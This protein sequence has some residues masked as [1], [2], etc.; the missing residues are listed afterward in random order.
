MS[1]SKQLRESEELEEPAPIAVKSSDQRQGAAPLPPPVVAQDTKN[2]PDKSVDDQVAA[3][4]KVA[5]DTETPPTK[6]AVAAQ[7]ANDAAIATALSVEPTMLSTEIVYVIPAKD[8]SLTG[9]VIEVSSG[10]QEKTWTSIGSLKGETVP[11]DYGSCLF[12]KGTCNVEAGS[13]TLVRVK[14]NKNTFGGK[15]KNF[16]GMKDDDEPKTRSVYSIGG[17]NFFISHHL[18]DSSDYL[19]RDAVT[20]V[21]RKIAERRLDPMDE[22]SHLQAMLAAWPKQFWKENCAQMFHAKPIMISISGNVIVTP[23]ELCSAAV[24]YSALKD[25][26]P[27]YWLKFASTGKEIGNFPKDTTH[28]TTL[29]MTADPIVK[30][31]V[32]NFIFMA[33][34]E[35]CRDFRKHCIPWIAFIVQSLPHS[36]P[37]RKK[38]VDILSIDSATQKALCDKFGQAW[39]SAGDL[40]TVFSNCR[41]IEDLLQRLSSMLTSGKELTSEER[42]VFT[43]AAFDLL[44]KQELRLSSHRDVVTSTQDLIEAVSKERQCE[45]L[46]LVIRKLSESLYN[47]YLATLAPSELLRLAAETCKRAVALRVSTVPTGTKE[48]EPETQFCRSVVKRVKDKLCVVDPQSIQD[49]RIVARDL[50]ETLSSET[51][52]KLF[53]NGLSDMLVPCDLLARAA[54]FST[55]ASNWPTW[56]R[57]SERTSILTI[58]ERATD[59]AQIY[60][61]VKKFAA[62]VTAEAAEHY[63]DE[64]KIYTPILQRSLHKVLLHIRDLPYDQQLVGILENTLK[65]DSASGRD[66]S[67]GLAQLT[68]HETSRSF[69]RS[70]LDDQSNHPS[71]AFP[72]FTEAVRWCSLIK[73]AANQIQEAVSSKNCNVRFIDECDKRRKELAECEASLQ[74][75]RFAFIKLSTLSE[76]QQFVERIRGAWS[77]AIEALQSF[78]TTT[79]KLIDDSVQEAIRNLQEKQG[80]LATMPLS[81]WTYPEELD[82]IPQDVKNS[83]DF[84]KQ[85]EVSSELARLANREVLGEYETALEQNNTVKPSMSFAETIQ[86]WAE[87]LE[88]TKSRWAKFLED[89]DSIPF[90]EFQRRFSR[91]FEFIELRLKSAGV[92]QTGGIDQVRSRHRVIEG[93]AQLRAELNKAIREELSVAKKRLP[94]P[95]LQNLRCLQNMDETSA[96]IENALIA[97]RD[98]VPMRAVVASCNKL[99]VNLAATSP[100]QEFVALLDSSTT[101]ASALATAHHKITSQRHHPLQLPKNFF[102]GLLEAINDDTLITLFKNHPSLHSLSQLILDRTNGAEARELEALNA[103]EAIHRAFSS[104]EGVQNDFLQFSRNRLVNSVAFFKYMEEVSWCSDVLASNAATLPRVLEIMSDEV[105]QDNAVSTAIELMA[106]TTV[107]VITIGG[108]HVD[109]QQQQQQLHRGDGSNI[110]RLTATTEKRDK[111]FTH[112]DLEDVCFQ[113]TLAGANA[114]QS[115]ADVLANYVYRYQMI[116]S[117]LLLCSELSSA[118]HPRFQL[119]TLRIEMGRTTDDIEQE[120]CSELKSELDRW[121]EFKLRAE[122]KHPLLSFLHAHELVSCLSAVDSTKTS[123]D[124]VRLASTLRHAMLPLTPI[125]DILDAVDEVEETHE[126]NENASIGDELVFIH[127]VMHRSIRTSTQ[128]APVISQEHA[129]AHNIAQENFNR[130]LRTHGLRDALLDNPES[131]IVIIQLPAADAV[132]CSAVSIAIYSALSERLPL[133]FEMLFCD[134]DTTHAAAFVRRWGVDYSDMIDTRLLFCVTGVQRLKSRHQAELLDSILLQKSRGRTQNTEEQPKHATSKLFLVIADQGRDSLISTQLRN[135]SVIPVSSELVQSATAVCKAI[136]E[137][138]PIVIAQSTSPSSGKTQTAMQLAFKSKKRF[139]SAIVDGSVSCFVDHVA[140]VTQGRVTAEEP[141]ILHLSVS[142]V[143]HGHRMNDQILEYAVLGRIVDHKVCKT[144]LRAPQDRIIVEIPSQGNL[145]KTFRSE[146]PAL[147]WFAP[148]AVKKRIRLSLVQLAA[149]L[150]PQCT[151]HNVISND[152]VNQS[153]QKA[154][155]V[156]SAFEHAAA[157]REQRLPHFETLETQFNSIDTRKA[158]TALI[159]RFC[160]N[161][162]H[163]NFGAVVRFT[164]FLIPMLTG[165]HEFPPYQMAS[166]ELELEDRR[167]GGT[168]PQHRLHNFRALAFF[169]VKFSLESGEELAATSVPAADNESTDESTRLEKLTISFDNLRRPFVLFTEGTYEFITTDHDD[170]LIASVFNERWNNQQRLAQQRAIDFDK[171]FDAMA[172]DLENQKTLTVKQALQ[173]LL[174]GS[175]VPRLNEFRRILPALGLQSNFGILLIGAL[176]LVKSKKL[177][178]QSRFCDAVKTHASLADGSSELARV[179]DEWK[180]ESAS[181]TVKLGKFC[182]CAEKWLQSLTASPK[183][184]TAPFVLTPDSFARLLA[185]KTRLLCGIPVVFQGE[186]G[187]GKTHLLGHL[188]RV[189][190]TIFEIIN[191]H[192]GVR[193]AT[194]LDCIHKVED[195][196]RAKPKKDQIAIV[197]LDEV[198]SMNDVWVAKSLVC[199][200]LLLGQTV[201]PQIHFVC[202]MNPWRLQESQ[203]TPGLDLIAGKSASDSK[204]TAAKE[205]HLV[206]DVNRSPESFMSV[207]W[208]FGLAHNSFHFP[209]DVQTHLWADRADVPSNLARVTDEHIFAE[210]CFSWHLEK[211]TGRPTFD[212]CWDQL[213]SVGDNEGNRHFKHL[214]SLVVVL[215]DTA[216]DKL[217]AIGGVCS[218]SLRDIHRTMALFPLELVLLHYA[219][220]WNLAQ[221]IAGRPGSTKSASLDALVVSSDR[222]CTDSRCRFFRF[223]K[224]IKKFVVQCT[225]ETTAQAILRVAKSAALHQRIRDTIEPVQCILVLEEVGIAVGSK[226][227]PLMVLHSLI[228]RGVEM[229]DGTL[230]RIP[231]IGISNYSLDAAKMNRMRITFRGNPKLDDLVKTA[232]TLMRQQARRRQGG[233]ISTATVTSYSSNT[234][235]NDEWV[236]DYCATFRNLILTDSANPSIKWYYGMRD[237]YS[238]VAM[239]KRHSD[240]CLGDEA[241]EHTADIKKRTFLSHLSWWA[242]QINFG[243][244][245]NNTLGKEVIETL[246]QA[247]CP[248]ADAPSIAAWSLDEEQDILHAD[249]EH[250]GS[251]S[252]LRRAVIFC[253]MCARLHWYNS[254]VHNKDEDSQKPLDSR[255]MLSSLTKSGQPCPTNIHQQATMNSTLAY[256]LHRTAPEV[257]RLYRVRNV[258]MFSRGNAGMEL[259]FRLGFVRKEDAEV[260][261]PRDPSHVTPQQIM[262]DLSRVRRCL[263]TNRTL[264]LVR[265]AHLYEAMFD[266]LNQHFAIEVRG[267]E[268]CFYSTLTV[269]GFTSTIRVSPDHRIILVEDEM[270]IHKLTSPFLN[271]CVKVHLDFES[272][273]T[274]P[275]RRLFERAK[276]EIEDLGHNVA[277]ILIPGFTDET[278]ASHILNIDVSPHDSDIRIRNFTADIIDWLYNLTSPRRLLQAQLGLM[279]NVPAEK[280]AGWSCNPIGATLD[281][282]LRSNSNTIRRHLLVFTEQRE[283]SSDLLITAAGRIF[284]PASCLP[285]RTVAVNFLA[286]DALDPLISGT[287]SSTPTFG[288]FVVDLSSV[289]GETG[290][291]KLDSLLHRVAARCPANRHIVVVAVLSSTAKPLAAPR[292]PSD[293]EATTEAAIVHSFGSLNWRLTDRVDWTMIFMDEV[294]PPADPLID[295]KLFLAEEGATLE[296]HLGQL[297]VALLQAYAAVGSSRSR[298]VAQFLSSGED[299]KTL[300]IAVKTL[301]HPS[302]PAFGYLSKIFVDGMMQ[303]PELSSAESWKALALTTIT[304]S[305]SVRDHLTTFLINVA[306]RAAQLVIPVIMEEDSHRHAIGR[307]VVDVKRNA[308]AAAPDASFCVDHESMETLDALFLELLHSSLVPGVDYALCIQQH[309]DVTFTPSTKMQLGRCRFPFSHRIEVLMN[310]VDG[311]PD[312]QREVYEELFL[313]HNVTT[314]T[315]ELVRFYASDVV[316]RRTK[317][318][319]IP[320]LDCISSLLLLSIPPNSRLTIVDVHAFVHDHSGWLDD[321]YELLR[322]IPSFK[323]ANGVQSQLRDLAHGH[324]NREEDRQPLE[325]VQAQED[326][327]RLVVDTCVAGSTNGFLSLSKVRALKGILPFAQGHWELTLHQGMST[328]PTSQPI[329]EAI[330]QGILRCGD[331]E[332]LIMFMIEHY[333]PAL[334]E[335]APS[336]LSCVIPED[337]G[338]IQLRMLLI[339]EA[340]RCPSPGIPNAMW[341][342][343]LRCILRKWRDTDGHPL[344]DFIGPLL[345]ED[346]HNNPKDERARIVSR[347]AFDIW[348]NDHYQQLQDKIAAAVVNQSSRGIKETDDSLLTFLRVCRSGVDTAIGLAV[349]HH[350]VS[351]GNANPNSTTTTASTPEALRQ[352]RRVESAQRYLTAAFK[353]NAVDEHRR[354]QLG[355]FIAR[356]LYFEVLDLPRFRD[357]LQSDSRK[358]AKVLPTE[359]HDLDFLVTLKATPPPLSVLDLFFSYAP[360]RLNIEKKLPITDGTP[361]VSVAAAL[362]SLALSLPELPNFDTTRFSNSQRGLLTKLPALLKTAGVNPPTSDALLFVA[363]SMETHPFI[364]NALRPG[365]IIQPVLTRGKAPT[366]KRELVSYHASKALDAIVA[367]LQALINEEQNPPNTAAVKDSVRHIQEQILVIR[368][369]RCREP[370]GGFDGCFSVT[371]KCGQCFCGWCF[372]MFGDAHEHLR[373]CPMNPTGGTHGTV[374]QWETSNNQRRVFGIRKYLN[375]V[376]PQLCSAVIGVL[377]PDLKDLHVDIGAIGIEPVTPPK[378]HIVAHDAVNHLVVSTAVSL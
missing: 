175:D 162:L 51:L 292:H 134:E 305:D 166:H 146:A 126:R 7:V 296:D 61:K 88:K 320:E 184:K 321:S 128:H 63:G 269:D 265:A 152:N 242:L 4:P 1:K 337:D 110:V 360:T 333:S 319:A 157:G 12:V 193:E 332:T 354:E 196:L 330:V 197:V 84:W 3:P 253:D 377:L 133:P 16:A 30:H 314:P 201:M 96:Q 19:N 137:S 293:D 43:R 248:Q 301:I 378:T 153:L 112:T 326:L 173:A 10:K 47:G 327:F 169:L 368:C 274:A 120:I 40:R 238:F 69:F 218:V 117:A 190:G 310:I 129:G 20:N 139:A 311:E 14:A 178:P 229:D 230:I 100:E 336:L 206:Y 235:N 213:R 147:E 64:S 276:K 220:C 324:H 127:Q 245:P 28:V 194:I 302:T 328:L 79:V 140:T 215:V 357:I 343:S 171:D 277:R 275:Q 249:P 340:V 342:A 278:L 104:T 181:P 309:S 82:K 281:D 148:L 85:V 161:K 261:D 38:I 362:F 255:F 217:R 68:R 105:D 365:A 263:R 71:W 288:V 294:V 258:L 372:G 239:M 313:T 297:K 209:Q 256:A 323:L 115:K 191:I 101:S 262:A 273:L 9:I 199:D 358:V 92:A 176:E 322:G 367:C 91:F 167:D 329:P 149:P 13:K 49:L 341:A 86:L 66:A 353:S 5:R 29:L 334:N 208:D 315:L 23:E 89:L 35:V 123:V 224:P 234:Q 298:S 370:F 241:G 15:V 284:E 350:L 72:E 80:R 39:M 109:Q 135:T 374:Q 143:A 359:F 67:R 254:R 122:T 306:Q 177:D 174:H 106:P 369:P 223:W 93:N 300:E 304:T 33:V 6:S 62:T 158:A 36:D 347:C 317:I 192:R 219:S 285:P 237:F 107:F 295:P 244:H 207:V 355:E 95:L 257:V 312:V 286:D 280:V 78:S 55:N 356:A 227:N 94:G 376:N 44:R 99:K 203:I 338:S 165:I 339:E 121:K 138:L 130:L 163:V 268:I 59:F 289:N 83:I 348:Q 46:E 371:C 142:H 361:N 37:R 259:L 189:S 170:K 34:G 363:A 90:V 11:C 291:G 22:H 179:S 366:A 118:G 102:P 221:I 266:V 168:M 351:S 124:R 243:G 228:D 2:P 364:T 318:T 21:L 185:V 204:E 308:P 240:Y 131:D 136:C 226:H 267:E 27:D 271:R 200:R 154:L 247:I 287:S 352:K 180:D 156:L 303:Q 155:R 236:D 202:I 73:D 77:N 182:V 260:I 246:H 212:S 54:V 116:K 251:M 141:I 232:K 299:V 41:T 164:Q 57:N 45:L 183:S 24:R 75:E 349:V 345:L 264:I 8:Q 70:I 186:T 65:S 31:A 145:H 74:S 60:A 17:V 198:N 290:S 211:M 48:S 160:P 108:N 56:L 344:S 81:M 225:R 316:R 279:H 172:R 205:L 188:S 132:L 113:L 283:I 114:D 307:N 216:Q 272:A 50:F 97:V 52:C 18:G 25:V 53:D 210:S 214:R 282:V 119:Q 42:E 144:A 58:L 346:I 150:T 252:P 187:Q 76:L 222:S 375:D 195:S 231:I 87:L 103:F 331:A 26:I 250:G 32:E 159:L 233:L 125:S 98:E 111:P 151:I 373:G 335:I 270:N 325:H